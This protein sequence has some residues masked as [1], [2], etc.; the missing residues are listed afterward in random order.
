MQDSA[1]HID[2]SQINHLL[3][4]SR[5]LRYPESTLFFCLDGNGRN[6]TEYIEELY[7]KG[8][9]HF[10]VKTDYTSSLDAKFVHCQCP[11]A[12]LQQIAKYHRQFY[13]GQS[14]AITGSNGKTVVKEWLFQLLSKQ[15]YTY[16]SPKSYNSQVGVPLSLWEIPLKSKIAII[17]AGI[18]LPD[19]MAKL[20]NIIKPNI[21]IFTNLGNAHQ[22]NFSSL[23][24]KAKEKL[25]LFAQS[26]LIIYREDD[27][28]VSSL[29]KKT[30]PDKKLITWSLE[31]PK[32]HYYITAD[33]KTQAIKLFEDGQ[34]LGSY[35][36]PFTDMAS[37][38]NIGHCIITALQLGISPAT[39]DISKMEAIA[40]RLEHKQGIQ[41]CSLINDAYNSDILS[42][43]IALDSLDQLSISKHLSKTVI[44]SDIEQSGLA[45][46]NLYHQISSLLK[47]KKINRL[48]A[49][50]AQLSKYKYLFNFQEQEFH[51]DTNSYLQHFSA[52]QFKNEAILFKGARS[53]KFEGIIRL[54]EERRHQTILEID[55]NALRENFLH[56][57][58][59]LRPETMIMGMVK[60]FAYGSGSLEVARALQQQGCNYLA[61]A[62]ADEGV[63]LR[64]S[65]ITLPIAVMTPERN[66]F[67]VMM[68]YNLEPAIYSFSELKAFIEVAKDAQIQN[69]PVHLKFDTGMHRL[70]FTEGD[71]DEL[72]T[73][74]VSQDYLKPVSV[75]S[76]LSSADEEAWDAFTK[77]QISTF[78]SICTS[79]EDKL[80]YPLIK[81]ILNSAGTERFTSHQFDMVRLGI[82][83][84]GI[85]ITKQKMQQIA[86]LK[87]AITQTR[88]LEKDETVGYGRKG[89]LT[90]ASRIATLPIGYADGIRRALGN[91]N[92]H[93]IIKGQKAP[94]VGNI[95]MD[96]SMVDITDI[97]AQEGD[98]VILLGEDIT[99]ETIAQQINTIPYEVFTSISQ[100]VKRVYI[101]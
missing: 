88:S 29:I 75:F 24:E 36:F 63:D 71:I 100:R 62:V 7:H 99:A 27:I 61:V 43:G 98:E 55:L 60:A 26:E 5:K 81:H 97:E 83:M 57:R 69:Y 19:E 22:E 12:L 47:A 38:E 3:T 25:K 65:G 49:I 35:P 58:R 20:E 95:C 42:L 80:K 10:V 68:Q 70:G 1:P 15:Y 72:T 4:D 77:Q 74:I 89:V 93:V 59:L 53:F 82:G 87:T 31:D 23:E 85:S 9:R 73:L 46:D 33:K 41:G 39:I 30:Y 92:G 14:I 66:S 50:G 54:L 18:S 101:D 17:E 40:M 56:F 52:E 78:T 37:L 44:L 84:Y 67:E 8:V 45:A 13:E 96:L 21:G 16:R 64:N 51:Q 6:G 86:T 76:H 32:A 79:L 34:Q 48:I 28:L 90:K 11:I 2:F 91:R 94:F